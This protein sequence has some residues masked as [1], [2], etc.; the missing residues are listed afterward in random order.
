MILI[1][2]SLILLLADIIVASI[3]SGKLPTCVSQCWYINGWLHYFL[4]AGCAIALMPKMI[5]VTP[6]NYQIF[7]FA[8]CAALV[9]VATAP[10]YL[11]RSQKIIHSVSAI[12]CAACAIAWAIV[13]API[14]LF[15]C[16]LLILALVEK[17]SRLLWLELSA[18]AT[19]YIGMIT[20]CLY[21]L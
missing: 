16:S 2:I 8:S 9:F 15:G 19:V 21:C 7:A 11:E 14:G 4:L 3:Y 13:T 6:D 12:V 5:S 20:K 1:V 18:F 17:R 10:D